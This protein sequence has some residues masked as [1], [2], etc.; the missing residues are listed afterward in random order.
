MD[1]STLKYKVNPVS[2]WKITVIPTFTF[3]KSRGVNL[4]VVEFSK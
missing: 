4:L 2:D 1:A 3:Y